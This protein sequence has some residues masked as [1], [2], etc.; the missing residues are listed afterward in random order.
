MPTSAIVGIQW[1]D[2]GKGR[3]VDLVAENYDVVVRF[4]GG[5]NA[6]HTVVN[7]LGTFKL[8]L[9]P[10]GIFRKSKMN[11]LGNGT[12]VDLE[13]ICGEMDRV[14]SA[15]VEITPE[16]FMISDRAMICFPYHR[17]LDCY[18]EERLAGAKYGSTRRGIAPC[19]GDQAM[20]KNLQIGELLLPEETIR[21]RLTGILEYKNLIVEKVYGKKPYSLDEIMDW[22]NKFGSRLKPFIGD[23]GEVITA[24][25]KAGKKILFEGQLGALRD[26]DFGIYPYTSSSNPLAAYAPVGCGA[27]NVRLNDVIGVVKAYSTCVG[28]GPFVCEWFGEEA[29]KLRAAGG[30]YGAATGRPRRVGPFDV[31]AAKYGTRVQGADRLALTKMDVIS[32]MEKIPVCVGYEIDGKVTDKFPLTEL[33]Y[34][35][36]PVM[37]YLDGWNCDISGIRKY[38]DLPQAA[39]DYVEYLEK[40]LECRIEFVS[41]G[42]ERDEIIQR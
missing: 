20:K 13:H 9:M 10:S 37:E 22:I 27:P 6:G 4:Q 5:N 42:A 1:G 15:G 32:Y 16:N 14:I 41:V 33:Q 31:V 23:A 38:D 21:E 12:V 7:E 19:Y 36:K 29:E 8:N 3:M 25:Y 39:K 18:E 35:A 30:E 40:K 11:I 17:D 26:I 2:E 24:A 34:V 28:E